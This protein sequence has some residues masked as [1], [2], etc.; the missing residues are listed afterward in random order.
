MDGAYGVSAAERVDVEEGKGPLALEELER[1]NLSYSRCQRV[2][3]NGSMMLSC[4]VAHWD[5]P[6]MILQKM[7]EARLWVILAVWVG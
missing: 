1:G 6:L 5:L 2:W 3:L 4:D 7:Q